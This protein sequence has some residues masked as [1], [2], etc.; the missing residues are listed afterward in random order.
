MK[1][2]AAYILLLVL[3]D[4]LLGFALGRMYFMTM[5]GENGGLINYALT[6]RPVV[7]I[8][9]ASG[10]KHHYDP[11]VL[12]ATLEKEAFNAGINGQGMLYQLMLFDL[13]RS[14]D[15]P[16]VIVL[17][18]TMEFLADNERDLPYTR[19]FAYYM[20]ES[21]F[22]KETI[23]SISPFE[24][25]KYLSSTYRANG[26][27]LSIIQNVIREPDLE[28]K[29]FIG[30]DGRMRNTRFPEEAEPTIAHF[31]RG[32][33]TRL[34]TFANWCEKEGILLFLV[35]GPSFR[36]RYEAYSMWREEVSAVCRPHRNTHFIEINQYTHPETFTNREYFR[37]ITHLNRKG[38]EVFS[39]LLAG[40]VSD[41]LGSRK[42]VTSCLG[43]D[44]CF[45]RNCHFPGRDQAEALPPC[46]NLTRRHPS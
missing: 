23:F 4:Q 39:G 14:R 27:V 46:W 21:Q 29:G 19:V 22:I 13:L 41:L 15:L 42:Q 20:A 11:S 6:K 37:D 17:D 9:G 5:S 34:K 28:F 45:P 7:L 12:E 2:M 8:M 40:M 16:E 44:H 1:R 32:G 33:M 18:V 25:I 24:R 3:L 26:K 30:L 31:T 35:N 43:F 10:A 36:N 38:A